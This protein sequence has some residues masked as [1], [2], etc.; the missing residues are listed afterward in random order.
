MGKAKV[1]FHRC[2]D[3]LDR[4][5]VE[6]KAGCPIAKGSLCWLWRG[7]KLTLTGESFVLAKENDIPARA[8]Q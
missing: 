3:S 7:L 2:S 8:H 1:A 5:P 6:N 4:C